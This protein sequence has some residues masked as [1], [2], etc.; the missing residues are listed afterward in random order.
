MLL[1]AYLSIHCDYLV[2]HLVY[3]TPLLL[4]QDL[5]TNQV[6]RA[7]TLL[8][9]KEVIASQPLYNPDPNTFIARDVVKEL[10]MHCVRLS[11]FAVVAL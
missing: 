7:I 2:L 10:S 5:D 4:N 9:T 3:I 1:A 6:P 11:D 8:I